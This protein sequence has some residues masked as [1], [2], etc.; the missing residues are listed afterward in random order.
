VGNFGFPINNLGKIGVS[1]KILGFPRENL[2]FRIKILGNLVFPIENLGNFGKFGVS[3][4]QSGKN[5]GF[6]GDI[7]VSKGKFAVSNKTFWR[8]GVS[9]RRFWKF[10]FPIEIWGFHK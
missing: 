5:W 1:L 10:G 9:N 3:N 7:G 6:L 8:F 2:G 4:K